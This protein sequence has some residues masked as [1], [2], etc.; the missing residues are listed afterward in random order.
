MSRDDS[1]LY[2]GSSSASFGTA[3]EQPLRKKRSEE[4]KENLGKLKPA[5]DVVFA[6]IK[7]EKDSV[8]FLQNIPVEDAK[9]ERLFMIEVMARKKYMEY[10]TRLQNKL[11]NILREPKLPKPEKESTDE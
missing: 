5:A 6:E 11:D 4:K 2:S 7:A 9:D 10:L 8:M 3:H 1:L